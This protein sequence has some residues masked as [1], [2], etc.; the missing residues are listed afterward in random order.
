MTH[1]YSNFQN[2]TVNGKSTRKNH[3]MSKVI[4]LIGNDPEILQSLAAEFAAN[5]GDIALAS[6]H[7]PTE[8]SNSIRER[9]HAFG[10]RF[11]LVDKSLL[12][13]IQKAETI[14]NKVR[15]VLGGIDIF[16]DISAHKNNEE[17]E[18]ERNQESPQPQWWL[19]SAILGEIKQ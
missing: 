16:I 19:S 2:G 14:V 13:N 12:N 3:L 11:L 15:E 4:L 9:V 7:L 8:I 17:P 18:D 6:S 10:G 1:S 5:G